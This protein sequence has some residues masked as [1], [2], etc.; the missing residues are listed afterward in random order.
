MRT[1][2]DILVGIFCQSLNKAIAE[3]FTVQDQ[4]PLYEIVSCRS[5]FSAVDMHFF[6]RLI[7]KC[8]PQYFPRTW[9]RL[10]NLYDHR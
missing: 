5:C 6:Y 4:L 10:A 2:L 7:A 8:G 1:L 9:R 3:I